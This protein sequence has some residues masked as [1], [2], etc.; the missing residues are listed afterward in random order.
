MTRLPAILLCLVAASAQADEISGDWCSDLAAHLR[1]AGDRITTPGGQET[2]GVY[3]RH[4][5]EFVVP[6]GERDAGLTVRMQQMSEERVIVTYEGRTP[7]E[8]HRCQVVS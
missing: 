6:E 4:S 1:I 8:W 2:D 3:G 7:E 5:Y